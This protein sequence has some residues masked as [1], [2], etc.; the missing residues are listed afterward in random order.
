MNTFTTIRSSLSLPDSPFLSNVIALQSH[1]TENLCQKC[2]VNA[3]CRS[4]RCVCNEG[5][6]GD[7]FKC[8]GKRIIII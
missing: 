1:Q 8:T 7:G 4:G 2:D 3:A 6:K 5:F